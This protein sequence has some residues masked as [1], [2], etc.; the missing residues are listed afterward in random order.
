MFLYSSETNVDQL[1]TTQ[2]Q[3]VHLFAHEKCVLTPI[4]TVTLTSNAPQ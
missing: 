1:G 4:N 3:K 2:L